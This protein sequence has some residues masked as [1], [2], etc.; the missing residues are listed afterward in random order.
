M[1]SRERVIR[2]LK[3]KEPDKIPLDLGGTESS[4]FTGIAYNKLKNHLGRN[5]G[6]TQIFDVYQQISKIEGPIRQSFK[7]DT[8]PLL[9][10]PLNWKSFKLPDGSPCEI[11]EKWNPRKNNGGWIVT[12]SQN[13]IT[14]RMP[15][16]GFYF[17]PVFAPLAD[18][19]HP[20]QL[21]KHTAVIESFDWPDF[22]D[23][24]LDSITLRSKSLF[25]NTEYA[26]I[27]NLQLHLLAAGQI[28]R[29]FDNFMMDLVINKKLAHALLER[30][31]EAYIKRCDLILDRV[32][33]YVQVVLVNDDLGTQQGPMMSMDCYK[34]MIWPYQKKL[35]G[36]IKKKSEVFLLFHSCGSVSSYIPFF[37]EAGV[38]ALNPVQ[39]SAAEME[40]SLLK[41]EYGKDITFWGGGCDTQHILNKGSAVEIQ[42]EV[43]RRIQDLGPGGG[44]VFTQ[45]HNIQPDV[46]PISVVTMIESFEKHST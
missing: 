7:V 6:K 26:I 14:A 21:D 30:L 8:I 25:E 46:P 24:P 31:V 16:G 22:A 10:E 2:T 17:E 38:D 42:D 5:E 29:G 44:F 3:R 13:K 36:Y 11:P 34:E 35:F 33:K 27:A 23:E 45:V 37:I 1:T 20:S 18:V 32:G 28:L 40:T 9:I 41:K 19:E 4:G 15:E 39:V 12:D 43:K